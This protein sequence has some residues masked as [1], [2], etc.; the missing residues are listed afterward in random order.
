M[1]QTGINLEHAIADVKQTGKF[2]DES[3]LTALSNMDIIKKVDFSGQA[4]V[5]MNAG[6]TPNQVERQ[7][8]SGITGDDLR[9]ALLYLKIIQI[10]F[11]LHTECSVIY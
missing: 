5:L 3:R 1:D 8:I 2:Q 4:N 6:M 10:F 7:G 9:A 11:K